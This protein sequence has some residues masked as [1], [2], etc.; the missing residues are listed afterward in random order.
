M[1][2]IQQC[3]KENKTETSRYQQ[4]FAAHKVLFFERL[5]E[6]FFHGAKMAS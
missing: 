2:Q 5:R 1:S 3:A 6:G 4:Q